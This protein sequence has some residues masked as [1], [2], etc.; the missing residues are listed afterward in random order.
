MTHFLCQKSSQPT[1]QIHRYDSV[2][3]QQ[4]PC[5]AAQPGPGQAA[6][7]LL[8]SWKKKTRLLLSSLE[9]NAH[10][11]GDTGWLFIRAKTTL[12]L[13]SSPTTLLMSVCVGRG[14]DLQD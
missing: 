11:A 5:L 1:I 2:A 12:G 9:A 13:C 7:A 3:G 14:R 8:W 4:L 6:G 10:P